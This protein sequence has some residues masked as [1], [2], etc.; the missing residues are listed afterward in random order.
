M[1]LWAAK[2]TS[3]FHS[4]KKAHSQCV[5]RMCKFKR[6]FKVSRAVNMNV[7]D[8]NLQLPSGWNNNYVSCSHAEIVA[9]Y[10]FLM[11]GNKMS[12][13]KTIASETFHTHT[14][15]ELPHSL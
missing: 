11:A 2:T 4:L 12:H 5:E 15:E 14:K 1:T 3:L 7:I 13:I 8:D 9:E 6:S 10:V